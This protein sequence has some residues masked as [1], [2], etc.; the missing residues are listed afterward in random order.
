MAN[1]QISSAIATTSI[2][3]KT[4]PPILR[5]AGGKRKHKWLFEAIKQVFN[6]NKHRLIEPFAGGLAIA[7][8]IEP[9][10]ALL[11]DANPFLISLYRRIKNGFEIDPNLKNY[12]SKESYYR[13]RDRFN[14]LLSMPYQEVQ[15]EITELFYY[16]NR[17]GYN[18]LCRFNQS[19]GYNTPYGKLPKPKLDHDFE[20]YRDRFQD[21]VFTSMDFADIQVFPH[22]IVVADPPY[23]VA[24]GKDKHNYVAGGFDWADQVRLADWLESANVPV[25]ACNLATDRIINLYTEKGFDIQYVNAPRAIACNGDRAKVREILATKNLGVAP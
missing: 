17:T 10:W 5:W 22:D 9:K 11:N 19:G 14:T 2:K 12:T 13:L 15:T 25:F 1:K 7:L 16:L 23:D 20:A 21:W 8:G 3:E 4:L 24:E 6:P 18:G